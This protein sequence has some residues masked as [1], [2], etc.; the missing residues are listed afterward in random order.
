MGFR[1]ADLKTLNE[2]AGK[3]GAQVTTG[4]EF[5]SFRTFD[6]EDNCVEIYCRAHT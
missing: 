3:F 2:W 1:V 6:P 5:A 4:S